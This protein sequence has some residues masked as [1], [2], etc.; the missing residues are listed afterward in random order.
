MLVRNNASHILFIYYNP[1]AAGTAREKGRNYGKE[2]KKGKKGK[3]RD[4]VLTLVKSYHYLI[5]CQQEGRKGILG[6]TE[7]PTIITVFK[8]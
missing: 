8:S 4:D 6:P 3:G 1:D 5:L 2:R 7:K